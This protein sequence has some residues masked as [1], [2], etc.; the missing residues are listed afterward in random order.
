MPVHLHE[1]G[2]AI[3]VVVDKAAAPGDILVVDSDA[4]RERHVAE[5][6]VAVV[7]I[8]VAGVVGEVGFENVE[9]AV[10]VVVADGHAHSGLLVA[11][12]AVGASGH[13]G[14]IGE[15]SVVIVAEQNAG[16]GIDRDVNI[17]PAVV[18]EI[19]RRPR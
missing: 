5:G 11:V 17:R 9:P 10:A 14:D 2:P 13:D 19:S 8:E 18:V 4:G 16:L 15:G 1:V 12:L 3:V 6:A 7:V